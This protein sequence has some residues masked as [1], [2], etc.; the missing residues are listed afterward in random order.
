VDWR[1]KETRTVK[2][3]VRCKRGRTVCENHLCGCGHMFRAFTYKLHKKHR[4]MCYTT[5]CDM[6]E[7]DLMGRALKDSIGR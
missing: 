6:V 1:C 3:I 4:G 7:N 2:V 5:K